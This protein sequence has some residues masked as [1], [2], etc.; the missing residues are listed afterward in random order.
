V[1]AASTI[2][3]LSFAIRMLPYIAFAA[4]AEAPRKQ[5]AENCRVSQRTNFEAPVK[6]IQQLQRDIA[7]WR[8]AA[9]SSV[10]RFSFLRR[11][12]S[13]VRI[14]LGPPSFSCQTTIS[15]YRRTRRMRAFPRERRWNRARF[16]GKIV[17]KK[18]TLRSATRPL[19]VGLF[20][21]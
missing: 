5:M 8:T 6:I 3:L 7:L 2:R 9:S 1:S 19:N 12:R 21:S 14:V 20:A 17:G 10:E 13:H 16:A 11:Q 4:S 15:R 18:F